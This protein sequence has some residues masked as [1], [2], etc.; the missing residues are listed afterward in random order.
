[1]SE[2]L[3]VPTR[4]EHAEEVVRRTE[5]LPKGGTHKFFTSVEGGAEI[6]LR[7]PQQAHVVFSMSHVEFAPVCSDARDPAVR[8]YGCFPTVEQARAHA[9]RIARE[10]PCSLFVQRTHEW[11]LCPARPASLAD[12]AA[13]VEARL[14]CHRL[15]ATKND[16]EFDEVHDSRSTGAKGDGLLEKP[17][18]LVTSC[19]EKEVAPLFLPSALHVPSQRFAVVSFV[20]DL[21]GE[22]DVECLCRVYQCFD[23]EKAADQYVRNVLCREVVD[24]DIDVVSTNEW[25]HP[26]YAAGHLL[27]REEFRHPELNQIMQQRRR[28]KGRVDTFERTVND[29]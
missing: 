25:V 9:A 21:T 22:A 1:M 2:K 18:N 3:E 28:D 13:R 6:P 26:Q 19:A 23:D 8:L 29:V 16:R 14:E 20:R 27:M 7:E 4:S 15:A 11:F 10:E 17:A 12:E 24:F 5:A